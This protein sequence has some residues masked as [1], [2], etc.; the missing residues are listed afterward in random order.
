MRRTVDILGVSLPIA[1]ISAIMLLFAYLGYI[2]PFLL[3]LI[4][5]AIYKISDEVLA[6]NTMKISLLY[7]FD[8]IFGVA[9]SLSS[10][11]IVGFF[12]FINDL[13]TDDYSYI[14]SRE[15]GL[16][17]FIEF[18]NKS[19]DFLDTAEDIFFL[20]LLVIGAISLIKNDAI[21]LPIAD[22]VLNKVISK[23]NN[24]NNPQA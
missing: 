2:T 23:K 22:G 12:T 15:S 24:N 21:K 16:S 7:V 9:L 13:I 4:V 5:G 8:L 14:T 11:L 3:I 10:K 19:F 20:V 17:K 1:I 6:A 18:L